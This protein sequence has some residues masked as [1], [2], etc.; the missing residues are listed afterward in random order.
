MEQGMGPQSSSTKKARSFRFKPAEVKEME[1]RLKPRATRKPDR[2]LIKELAEKFSYSLD[3]AGMIP[4]NPKQVLNW[5][6]YRRYKRD[7]KLA[8]GAPAIAPPPE[9]AGSSSTDQQQQR[10]LT[11]FGIGPAIGKMQAPPL[12]EVM[13]H[14]SGFGAE[15][16]EWI[17]A[18]TCLRQ[19]SLPCKATECVSAAPGDIVLC[20]KL[21]EKSS[22]Y[23]DAEV[24]DIE[25]KSHDSIACD[26]MFHVCYEHDKSEVLLHF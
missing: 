3:R 2:V 14:Y 4:V 7:T 19:R 18:R 23:F 17:N 16:A 26:C 21:S 6:R 25:R 15:E 5:F 10:Q 11:A 9:N 1:E 8:R 22:L 20:C 13:V 12:Q 24:K